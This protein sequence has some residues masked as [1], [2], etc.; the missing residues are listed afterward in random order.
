MKQL[1]FIFFVSIFTL[2]QEINCQKKQV[3]GGLYLIEIKFARKLRKVQL[4]TDIILKS[5]LLKTVFIK[6]KMETSDGEKRV[7]DVNKFSLV[8]NTNKVRSRPLSISYQELTKYY[9]FE[10]L[11]KEPITTN[12][13]VL[14][15]DKGI[16]DSFDNYSFEGYKKLEVPVNYGT[17]KNPQLHIVY[18]KPKNFKKR[19]INLFFPFIA[20]QNNGTLF[21]GKEKIAELI[22]N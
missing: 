13:G 18:F 6:V 9:G 7:F 10:K 8:D 3:E 20:K 1:T 11:T 5:D 2:V 12:K 22:F 19:K 21:Y 14:N 4:S 17:I 15:Y 16:L